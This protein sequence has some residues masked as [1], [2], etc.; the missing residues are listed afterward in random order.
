MEFADCGGD[1]MQAKEKKLGQG[2]VSMKSF[3]GA[4]L[5]VELQEKLQ[6]V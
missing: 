6:R 1:A 4:H 2:K 5:E 3:K